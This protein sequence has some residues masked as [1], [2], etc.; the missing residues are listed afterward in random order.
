MHLPT[1]L[2]S[3]RYVSFSTF[4]K[5]GEVVATPVWAADDG[6]YFYIFS[7]G[8]AGKVKRLRNSGRSQLAPCTVTGKLTGTQ[9]ET[10][11][12]LIDDSAS[13]EQAYA[14]LR[15]KYG[16]QMHLIDLISKIGG[17]YNQRALIRVAL[18]S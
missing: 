14:A 6:Q 4:R 15:K 8:E 13:V 10:T 5:S 12:A 2:T 18:N 1:E 11:A 3:A 7:E 9:F 17:R 16:W